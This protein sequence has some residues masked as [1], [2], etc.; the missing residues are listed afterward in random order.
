MG[1]CAEIG[2]GDDD[3]V[4]V[5]ERQQLFEILERTRSPSVDCEAA[6]AA[7]CSRFTF[8]RSQTAVISTFFLS[9]KR[10]TIQASSLPRWPMPMWPREMRSL[11]P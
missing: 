1:E 3:G 2:G 5:L 7:A 4:H 9:L 10:H 6:L 8:Q 11:A